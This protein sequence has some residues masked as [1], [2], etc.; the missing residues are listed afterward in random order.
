MKLSKN[1]R[2]RLKR[3]ARKKFLKKFEK[4]HPHWA[5]GMFNAVGHYGWGFMK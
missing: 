1:E 2:Q 4:A 3:K 5:E